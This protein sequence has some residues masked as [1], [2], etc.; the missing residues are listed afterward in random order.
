MAQKL[1]ELTA[2]NEQ[3]QEALRLLVEQ[4]LDKL[5]EENTGKLE[6]MRKTVDEKLQGTL[7]KRL[8]E[9]FKMVSE[10]LEKVHQGLGEMQNLA[11]GVGDLK[12]A[13]MNVKVRGGW[14]EVQLGALLEQMLT[15][16]QYV[17]NARIKP[18]SQ[19]VV[20]FAINLPGQ[21]DGGKEVLLPIDAK[22][23]HEDFDRL[24]EAMEQADAEAVEAAGRQL[25][26]SIRTEAKRISDKYIDPPV[27]TDFAILFLPTEGLFAEVIRRPGLANEIQQKYRVMLTGPTTL[28]ALLNSLQMGFRTLAIQKRSGEVWQVLGEAKAE[29]MKY[30]DV[31]DKVKKQLGT[32]TNT[33][34]E[35]GR[36][37][38]VIARKLR[39]VETLE[40]PRTQPTLIDFDDNGNGGGGNGDDGAAYD[41]SD[42]DTR[43]SD[44]G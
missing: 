32:V 8:G 6:E 24:N 2:A 44:I 7:E 28:G 21:D 43:T 22:F 35:A 15:P 37:T 11:T 42:D 41:D 40:P 25:E 16:E 27:T 10:R 34:D 30:G 31:W 33:V 3:R 29:F 9:S 14:A 1:A 23:P 13:L 17:K 4:R 19:E 38:R 5:R 20:E 26:R 39:D 12:R 18:Q 36:R